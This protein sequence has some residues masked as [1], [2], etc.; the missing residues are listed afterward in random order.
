MNIKNTNTKN[1]APLLNSLLNQVAKK[2]RLGDD[3]LRYVKG[4][5]SHVNEFEA[6]MIDNHGDKG[7]DFVSAIGAGT[8]NPK[9]GMK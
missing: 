6:N 9:T 2:G 1:N 4:E 7:E 8:T 3:T 5:L